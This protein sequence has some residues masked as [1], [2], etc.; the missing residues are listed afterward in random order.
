LLVRIGKTL[1]E[2]IEREE[3]AARVA[4]G[5]LGPVPHWRRRDRLLRDER[6]LQALRR[7][8]EAQIVPQPTQG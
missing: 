8:L 7:R 1:R 5:A 3:A 6:D 2:E 4:P